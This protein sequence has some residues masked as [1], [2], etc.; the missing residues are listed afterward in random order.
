MA[1]TLQKSLSVL[2][3]GLASGDPQLLAVAIL[4]LMEKLAA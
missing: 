1:A 3:N 4:R 2:S